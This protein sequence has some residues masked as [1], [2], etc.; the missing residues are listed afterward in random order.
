VRTKLTTRRRFRP[1]VEALV[2]LLS[3]IGCASGPPG[4]VTTRSNL[5]GSENGAPVEVPA[6]A[7]VAPR[8]TTGET[9]LLDVPGYLPAPVWV[10]GG[11]TSDEKP[12]VVAT[13]G[14]YDSPEAYCP[15]WQKIVQDRAFVLCTRGK[16]TKGDGAFYYPDHTFVDQEETVALAAL[17]SRFGR[18]ISPGPALYAGYS[19]GAIHGAPLLQT[20]PQAHPRAVLIEGG[21][22]WNARTAARYRAAGGQRILFVCGTSGCK[23]GATRAVGVLARAGIAVDFLWV[24]RAGHD[25]PLEMAIRIAGR[26]DWLVAGDPQWAKK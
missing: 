25:Y 13:H 2:A 24:P 4:S 16:R 10:P 20:R 17:R 1:R 8:Q 12:V 21:S 15:F 18:R 6:D 5:P 23:S 9:I 11:D 7:G 19:Q 22:S 14:A 26:L 3:A